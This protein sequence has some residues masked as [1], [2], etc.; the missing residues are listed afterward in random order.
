MQAREPGPSQDPSQVDYNFDENTVLDY[1]TVPPGTYLCRVDEARPG[2]TRSGHPRW[3]LKFVVHKGPELGR[4]A[5]W[6]GLTFSPKAAGRTRQVLGALGLP[7]E[8]RVRLHAQDL[9]GR[10]A[11]VSVELGEYQN[12]ET[13][14]IMRRNKVPYGG[15]SSA[16]SV[17]GL[18]ADTL[19]AVGERP[20]EQ[21]EADSS[22]GAD[23]PF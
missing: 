20:L 9:L 2:L 4:I 17:T 22:Q 23:I 13:G 1:G 3:G 14:Q 18:Q 7:H 10:L 15:V 5:A 8:G 21:A 19:P 16:E 11:F 6:D 12:P